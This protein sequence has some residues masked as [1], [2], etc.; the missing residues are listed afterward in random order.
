M[1][2]LN[3]LTSLLTLAK[4]VELC[5]KFKKREL[6]TQPKGI[7]HSSFWEGLVRLQLSE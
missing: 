3:L 6:P 7:I 1:V 4:L 5:E 2:S